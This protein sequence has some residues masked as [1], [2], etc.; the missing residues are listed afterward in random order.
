MD[1][2]IQ[3]ISPNYQ[4][5]YNDLIDKMFPEKKSSL[6]S[7]LEKET[8]TVLDIINL[9]NQIFGQTNHGFR[10]KKHRSYDRKAIFKILDYQKK[11][12]LNNKEVALKFQMSRNTIAKWK[13]IFM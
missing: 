5:I 9:N 10:T 7:I 6:Q 8:L 11:N 4:R 3:K 12:K 1:R 2:K 13:K